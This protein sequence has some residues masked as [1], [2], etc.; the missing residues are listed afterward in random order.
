MFGSWL[1]KMFELKLKRRIL[2]N[3][4]TNLNLN[5]N[6]SLIV[7]PLLSITPPLPLIPPLPLPAGLHTM[8]KLCSTLTTTHA[9]LED[10]KDQQSK[11]N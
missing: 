7:P 4:F 1:A 8:K 9:V 10:A 2:A 5:L 11:S 6:I 3:M